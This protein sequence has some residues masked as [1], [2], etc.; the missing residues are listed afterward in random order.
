MAIQSMKTF[1]KFYM[2]A[3]PVT[4]SVAANYYDIIRNPMDLFTMS[5]KSD[6]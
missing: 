2:F 5:G 3:E 6:R 4:K 1:D